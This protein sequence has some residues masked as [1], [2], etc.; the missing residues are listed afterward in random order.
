M[1]VKCIFFRFYCNFF[2]VKIFL[3]EAGSS[4][5]FFRTLSEHPEKGPDNFQFFDMDV[6]Q[7][8]RV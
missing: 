4:E 7:T 5:Y 1:Y 8:I 6:S 3:L 2:S